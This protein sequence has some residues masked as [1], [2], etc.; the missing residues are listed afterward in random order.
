MEFQNILL[1]RENA[2]Y[3][4]DNKC[5]ITRHGIFHLRIPLLRLIY[6]KI[7]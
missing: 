2:Q 4:S 6:D 7:F 5:K 3:H 1:E